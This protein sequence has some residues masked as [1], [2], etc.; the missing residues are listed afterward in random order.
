MNEAGV[1]RIK[2]YIYKRVNTVVHIEIYLYSQNIRINWF[3]A[4]TQYNINGITREDE[5]YFEIE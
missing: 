4:I 3:K 2:I 5:Q 1:I